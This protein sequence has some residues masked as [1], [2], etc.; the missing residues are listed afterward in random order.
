MRVEVLFEKHMFSISR[1]RKIHSNG[2]VRAFWAGFKLIEFSQSP[3]S[4]TQPSAKIGVVHFWENS[5]F[6][7]GRGPETS[8]MRG[9]LHAFLLQLRSHTSDHYISTCTCFGPVCVFGCL[10]VSLSILTTLYTTG[11]P[12]SPGSSRS[13][14]AL[15]MSMVCLFPLLVEEYRQP[16]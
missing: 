14:C 15:P 5:R 7:R 16:P 11:M 1:G 12:R 2:K 13:F 3:L 6:V 10:R 4:N 8:N 9:V